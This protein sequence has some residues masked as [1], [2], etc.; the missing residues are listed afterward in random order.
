M[1]LIS[2]VVLGLGLTFGSV[3]ACDT[4]TGVANL[5]KCSGGVDAGETVTFD[6]ESFTGNCR[7]SGTLIIR[8][9]AQI[10]GNIIG[11]SGGTISIDS[12]NVLGNVDS[13]GGAALTVTDSSIT[14]NV[15]GDGTGAVTVTGNTITGNLRL[16]GFT[17]CV[18]GDNSVPSPETTGCT[19]PPTP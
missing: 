2:L 4:V 18:A 16:E 19:E 13:N 1:K 14:G 7:V 12:S 10:T 9:G 5:A 11:E 15:I 3:A 8:N 6:D 17:T